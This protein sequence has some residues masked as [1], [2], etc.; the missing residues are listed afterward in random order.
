[1]RSHPSDLFASRRRYRLMAT[2]RLL[3]QTGYVYTRHPT[4]GTQT[5]VDRQG[6]YVDLFPTSFA[7]V[8]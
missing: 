5:D 7:F 8:Y 4:A 2:Y 1:M 6:E 3:L